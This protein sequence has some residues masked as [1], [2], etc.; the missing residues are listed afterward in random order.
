[1]PRWTVYLDTNAFIRFMESE[2]TH[3]INLFEMAGPGI[4]DLYTSE[5]T[6]A[7][8]LVSP[9]RDDDQKLVDAYDDFIGSDETL[10]VVPISRNIL[11]QSADLR[12]KLGGKTP[13][14]IHVAT[15]LASSCDVFVSSDQRLRLPDGLVR[16][17]IDKAGST[18]SWP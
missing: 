16:I 14:S 11:R 17:P 6:L 2:E 9:L 5:L 12:A 4:V 7:E 3:V 18:E 13:D 1:M 10:T 15:A 8:V